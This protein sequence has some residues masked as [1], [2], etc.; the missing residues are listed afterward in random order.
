MSLAVELETERKL[1]VEELKEYLS[2]T[3]GTMLVPKI[4]TMR[5]HDV[6]TLVR[7]A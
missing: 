2:D 6:E 1:D 3:C 7:L 4:M 5:C